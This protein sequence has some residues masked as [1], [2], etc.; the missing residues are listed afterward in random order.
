MRSQ[1]GG[2]M[3]LVPLDLSGLR[4]VRGESRRLTASQVAHYAVCEPVQIY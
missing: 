2:C 4:L 1:V 3:T